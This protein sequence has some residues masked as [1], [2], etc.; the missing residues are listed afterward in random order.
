MKSTS[1]GNIEV[2]DVAEGPGKF[3]GMAIPFG[4][5]I[6]V[7]YGR[8]VFVRGAFTDAAREINSGKR[9]AYLNRHGSDGGVPVG[10]ITQLQERDTGLYFAGE[11]L[12][13]PEAPQ[14]RSQVRSGINGVSVEFV[15]GKIRRK[16]DIIEHY[17]GVRLAAVAGSYAPAYVQANVQLRKVGEGKRKMPVLTVP[18]LTERRDAITS[19]IAIVRSLAE[20]EDRALS[21]V[22]TAEIERLSARIS[23]VDALIVEASAEQKRRDAERSALPRMGSA[24]I[25]RQEAIYGPHTGRSYFG[26]LWAAHNRDAA[27]MERMAKHRAMVLDLAHKLDTRAV[28]SNEIAGAYPTQNM[29]DLWVPDLVYQGPFQRFFASTPISAPNPI[30]VPSFASVTGDT[31]VQATENTALSNIDVATVPITVT[32]QTV[33]GET[34]VSRQ[35]VDGASPGTDVIIGVEL[36][37]LLMRD[38]E[39]AIYTELAKLTSKYTITDT[40]GTGQAQ[41]GKDLVRGFNSALADFY[42]VTRM[43]PAEH[44]FTGTNDWSNLVAG[45]DSTGRPVMP[46]INPVNSVGQLSGASYQQGVIGGVAVEPAWAITAQTTGFIARSNDARQWKSSV[47]EFRLTERNG[48]QSIVFA[49]WQYL[50]FAVLQPKG[51]AKYTYTNV[52]L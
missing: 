15:P 33:G 20:T 24:V 25:T 43:L 34:I 45:E 3:E 40:A 41:S 52:L 50:G 38:V 26:D 28:E 2:R 47:L 32:P 39:R 11:F 49:I 19:E 42:A 12:D 14:A 36:R 17:A 44:I 35:A 6:D 21:D 4:I 7:S 5:V 18:A 51:V 8:E 22:E 23:N 37:E 16:G 27:A 10:V 13:V 29:P 31:G 48:P 9:V 1:L 46:F 30:T